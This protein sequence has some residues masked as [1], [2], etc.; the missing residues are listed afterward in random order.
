LFYRSCFNEDFE[1]NEEDPF[2]DPIGLESGLSMAKK[3]KKRT[4]LDEKIK[5]VLNDDALKQPTKDGAQ[6][7][8]DV[9]DVDQN[10]DSEG[11]DNID[12]EIMVRDN[13]KERETTIKV[14]F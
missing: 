9:M 12:E 7:V 8:Q 5:K 6:A 10:E 14:S 13:V 4:T 11:D 3:K 2:L 1:F